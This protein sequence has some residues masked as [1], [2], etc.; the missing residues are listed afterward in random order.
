MPRTKKMQCPF[1][2]AI[3]ANPSRLVSHIERK[4]TDE[5]PP[6]M[7]P[8][9]YVY[10]LRTGKTH[11]RCVMCGKPSGWN[12]NTGKYKR[13]CENPK[14]K[15][16]YRE[17]FK[18]RMIGRYGKT[19][20]LRDPEQQRKMLQARKISGE[21]RWRDHVHTTPF[22]GTYEEDFL[23]FLDQCLDMDPTDIM[24]PSPHTYY[25]MYQGERHFYIPDFFIPSLGLEIEIKTHENMHHKIQEVDAV[26]ERLKDVVM[27][28]VQNTFDYIK[29]VD[30]NY[31]VLLDYFERSKERELLPDLPKKIVLDE[32]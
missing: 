4:H 31:M 15:E 1:C 18:K 5:I 28:S 3:A 30:K 17:E 7:T 9:Q 13:F 32:E 8:L 11:G 22:T 6:E 19:T 24:A 21:Y 27:K 2:D 26:K 14:C 29:I 16:K 10:Y 12:E 25:Y 23:R 20:L